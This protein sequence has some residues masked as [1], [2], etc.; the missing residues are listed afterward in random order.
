MRTAA[1]LAAAALL[2]LVPSASTAS[3]ATAQ[4]V[5][6]SAVFPDGIP[7]RPATPAESRAARAFAA[8][9]RAGLGQW[10]DPGVAMSA[11]FA[12]VPGQDLVVHMIRPAWLVAPDTPADPARPSALV[13]LRTSAGLRLVGGM[14]MM[15]APGRPG[16][17]FGG[18]LTP[19]HAHVDCRGPTGVD[20]P[21]P[22]PLSAVRAGAPRSPGLELGPELGPG[23]GPGPCAPGQ[24]RETSAEM[25]HV[26]LP[27]VPDAYDTA[28][29]PAVLVCAIR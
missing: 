10:R 2:G 9:A 8:S 3:S 28:M 25:L 7:Q 13:Y 16:P 6:T 26:W 11:G 4:P 18:P 17:D 20:V 19:W 5:P 27:G 24:T 15:A 29:D 12:P 14:W 22:L 21:P 1:A 23:P